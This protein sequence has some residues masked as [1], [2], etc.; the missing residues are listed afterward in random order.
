MYSIKTILKALLGAALLGQYSSPALAE[1]EENETEQ[2]V[3]IATKTPNKLDDVGSS[4]T[5]IDQEAIRN[6]QKVS[7]YDLLRQVPG[8]SLSRNGGIG[9]VS[10][11]RI[12]GAESGQ[13]LVLID[14]VKVNDLSSP[15]GAFNFANLTTANIERI[16][17]LRGP[18]STLYGSDAIGGVINIITK[19][20]DAPFSASGFLEGGSFGSAA[21]AVSLGVKRGRFSGNLSVSAMRT[22]GI[23]A[24]DSDA[25]NSERD[26][27]RTLSVVGNLSYR[28]LEN[29]KL[30]GFFRT[31]DSRAEFDAF[32]FNTFSFVDGDGVTKT[33]DLQA[34]LGAQ[35]SGLDGRVEAEARISWS[36]LDRFDSE[37]GGPSFS[38]ESRNRTID[39]LTTIEAANGLTLLVGGQFQAGEIF[40]EVFGFFAGTLTGT[41]N[42]NSAFAQVQVSPADN[43][44]L[45]FGVRHDD[46]QRFGGHTTLRITANFKIKETGTILRANWGEGFKAPSLFQLFSS[47]GDL[48]LR[49]EQ[50][51]GWEVGAEQPLFG[52]KA[53][54]TVTY[55]TRKT[56][57]QID[58]DLVTFKFANIARTRAKGVEVIFSAELSGKLSVSG[59]YTRLK[60]VN[61]VSGGML[62]R[63][64]K[65]IFNANVTWAATGRLMLTASLNHTGRQLDGDLVLDGFRVIDVR[66]SYR[67]NDQV[68]LYGRIENALDQDYQ[69]VAGF[70]TPGVSAFA[71]IRAGF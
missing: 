43:L 37:N 65:N 69:E 28:I 34:A 21:G 67:L 44:H 19:K 26:G 8:V 13:T 42:I 71:G 40:T 36:N 53:R 14:G 25:G 57:D 66:I 30:S 33:Q 32:D 64:P 27:F 15:S 62:L 10:T 24:A 1:E 11:L 4:V 49:P 46:H 20:A 38:S 17:I 7:V 54:L 12:R 3:V 29:L 47:F 39:L 31:G 18:E 22:D 16:E 48:G 23:S 58:F 60:A 50:S 61:L 41:A 9:T 5:L 56:S 70:G 51:Q 68:T 2:V 59:N 63:R 45:T 35:W 55:F 52:D 6:S